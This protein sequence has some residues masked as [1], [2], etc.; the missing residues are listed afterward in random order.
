MCQLNINS[1]NLN[2]FQILSSENNERYMGSTLLLST[3]DNKYIYKTLKNDNI[4]ELIFYSSIN[5]RHILRKYEIIP[6]FIRFVT[7]VD[8]DKKSKKI[9]FNPIYLKTELNKEPFN[10]NHFGH[11][12]AIEMENFLNGYSSLSIIDLKLGT[13]WI[14]ESKNDS[15]YNFRKVFFNI[16]QG[17][18]L[19]DEVKNI[20]YKIECVS[21]KNEFIDD[22]F[23]KIKSLKK[24]IK[25]NYTI[26]NTCQFDIGIRIQGLISEKI[27][28][29]R[30]KGKELSSNET[31]KLISEFLKIS[32]RLVKL[33]KKKL[34]LL[35]YWLKKQTTYRFIATSIVLAFDR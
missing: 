2:P 11:I 13:S 9:Y 16:F 22:M 12:T 1:S 28:I 29:S 7:I 31:I 32:P 5:R 10:I 19:I 34:K 8:S 27:T 35:Q 33:T 24:S 4:N 20:F 3:K 14:G 15:I 23:C 18:N 17:E 30:Q 21:K 25:Q 26:N 6:R